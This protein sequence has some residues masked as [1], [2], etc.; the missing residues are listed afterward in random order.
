MKLYE[1]EEQVFVD[2]ARYME[3][4]DGVKVGKAE[5]G[6]LLKEFGNL[7]RGLRGEPKEPPG[8]Y[9]RAA[10]DEK[11]QKIINF[12]SRSGGRL[13]VLMI[14]IDNFKE[15]NAKYGS[16]F[17]DF[18]LEAVGKALKDCL[19]RTDDFVARWGG[20]EFIA[21]LPSTGEEG[22]RMM[23][24]RMFK[25]VKNVQIPSEIRST[26][27]ELGI[28][29]GATTGSTKHTQQKNDYI[30]RAEEALSISQKNKQRF[31]YL[32]LHEQ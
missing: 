20:D 10:I 21:I 2:A 28:S 17:G 24:N 25:S 7:L 27:F 15:C 16:R 31:T 23:S 29:M 5:Y 30:T 32:D 22:A 4:V 11:L 13:S 6:E 3:S 14:D 8:S 19:K 9:D 1:R 18:C 12:L 26:G